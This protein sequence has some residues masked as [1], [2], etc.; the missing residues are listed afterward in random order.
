[1][2][3]LQTRL[4][5]QRILAPAKSLGELVDWMGALQAQDLNQGKWALGL[6]TWSVTEK[7]IEKAIANKEIV[8]TWPMRG[9]L[10]FISPKNIRW[11]CNLMTPRIISSSKGRHHQLDLTEDIFAKSKDIITKALSGNKQLIRKELFEILQAN[12]I[13]TDGQRG[14]HILGYL[15]QKNVLCLGPIRGKQPTFVLLDEWLPGTSEL[16]K[17]ESLSSI[18]QLYFQSHGP[19]TLKDFA[20]WTGMTIKDSQIAIQLNK[21]LRQFRKNDLEY[22]FI[23]NNIKP[24]KNFSDIKLLAGFDEY[25][26]SYTNKTQFVNEDIFK[27]HFKNKNGMIPPILIKNGQIIGTWKRQIKTKTVELS[28]ELFEN[29]VNKEELKKASTEF[30]DFLDKK[31]AIK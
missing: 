31:V 4:K 29:N 9:T 28:F 2:N 11:M 26:L 3:I 6:R 14:I 25:F 13:P 17:E 30:G 27:S 10:H 18:A 20:W 21:N 24:A 22:Y 19:A 23:E 16:S 5:N 12:G 15:A 1:M 8:R 7:D